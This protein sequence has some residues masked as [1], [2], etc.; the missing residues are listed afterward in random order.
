MYICIFGVSY[1]Y[2]CSHFKLYVNIFTNII[3]STKVYN[4][5]LHLILNLF[6]HFVFI[7]AEE[8]S[9]YLQNICT[10]N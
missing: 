3:I 9:K 1:T 7:C 6:L 5:K 10:C 2:I 8:S 4:V